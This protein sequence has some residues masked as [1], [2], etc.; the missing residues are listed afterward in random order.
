M[1]SYDARI[2][3]KDSSLARFKPSGAMVELEPV[4]TA[5]PW[6]ISNCPDDPLS[7]GEPACYAISDFR[8]VEPAPASPVNKHCEIRTY[9]HLKTGGWLELHEPYETIKHL[10]RHAQRTGFAGVEDIV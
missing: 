8:K 9:V 5:S 6:N 10:I 1:Q 3:V 7:K 4:A 2:K